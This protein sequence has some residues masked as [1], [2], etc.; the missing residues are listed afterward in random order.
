MPDAG[1]HRSLDAQPQHQAADGDDCRVVAQG[2]LVAS[3]ESASLLEQAEGALDFRA[4]LVEFLVVRGRVDPGAGRGHDRLTADAVEVLAEAMRA[5]GL[6]AEQASRLGSIHQGRRRHDVVALALRD[7][8][9]ERQA[10]RVD[11]EMNLRRRAATRA[12]DPLDCG[13]P[14]PPAAC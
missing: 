3:R 12:P 1:G 7:L 14:F 9:G 8:E 5:V 11:Y 4:R 6:V 10:Q 2:L 13:P